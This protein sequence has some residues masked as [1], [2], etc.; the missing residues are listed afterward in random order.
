MAGQERPMRWLAR[1]VTVLLMMLVSLDLLLVGLVL[2]G[3]PAPLAL[4][5]HL[6]AD[7][8]AAVL[9]AEADHARERWDR[10]RR[11]FD[12]RAEAARPEHVRQR[13]SLKRSMERVGE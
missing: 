8:Q 3:R 4:T 12:A 7:R 11:R 1:P 2:L 5:Q 6:A 9:D 13:T 10:F